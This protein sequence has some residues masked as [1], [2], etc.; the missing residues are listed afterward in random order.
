MEQELELMCLAVVVYFT[1]LRACSIYIN[2]FSVHLFL[3]G[4]CIFK[5][6]NVISE[7]CVVIVP[8]KNEALVSFS[9]DCRINL[10][11]YF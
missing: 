10:K 11:A 2:R 5:R 1:A 9:W 4:S 3:E 6:Q 7:G 8:F